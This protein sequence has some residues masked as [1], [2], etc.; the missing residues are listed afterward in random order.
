MLH[1]SDYVDVR[2]IMSD[3]PYMNGVRTLGP[4]STSSD[5]VSRYQAFPWIPSTKTQ[6]HPGSVFVSIWLI[7][8][9]ERGS[10]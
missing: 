9:Y 4:I 5:G 8:S 2:D 1:I 7:S 6:N 10:P 3:L